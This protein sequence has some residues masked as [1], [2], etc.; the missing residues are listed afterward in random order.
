MTYQYK[1]VEKYLMF[2]VKPGGNE[3]SVYALSTS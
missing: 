1:T 3:V 2:T